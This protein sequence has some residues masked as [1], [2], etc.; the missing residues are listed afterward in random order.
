MH[1][2]QAG[3]ET[4]NYAYLKAMGHREPR[5]VCLLH[6]KQQSIS[7][8]ICFLSFHLTPIIYCKPNNIY[9]R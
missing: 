6:K 4:V 7:I 3:I 8:S 1:D 9:K 5:P 2:L